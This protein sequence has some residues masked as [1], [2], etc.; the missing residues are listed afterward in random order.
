MKTKMFF[1]KGLAAGRRLTGVGLAAWAAELCGAAGA[2]SLG[3]CGGR[4]KQD[5]ERSGAQRRSAEHRWR[6]G[7]VF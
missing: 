5:V 1:K 4:D 2:A 7:C 3:L 6:V